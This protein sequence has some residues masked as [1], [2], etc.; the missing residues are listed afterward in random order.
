MSFSLRL[1]WA[2]LAAPFFLLLVGCEKPLEKNKVPV[3]DLQ[4]HRGA[5]GLLPENTVEGFIKALELGATTLEMDV[6]VTADSQAVLS[7][8]PWFSAEICS[9]PDGR[10]VSEKD[11][12][13]LFS[14][15]YDSIRQYDC[16]Q[17]GHPRFPKQQAQPAFKPLLRDVVNAVRD[18]CRGHDRDMPWFNIETKIK[19]EWEGRFTPSPDTFMRLVY[20]EICASGIRTYACVQSFDVRTLQVLQT[21]DPKMLCALLVE[22]DKPLEFNLSQ[23]GFVP[24]IY[25]PHHPLV[26]AALV[27]KAHG[28]QMRVIPWTVNDPSEIAKLKTLGVDGV[29]SDYPDLFQNFAENE[30]TKFRPAAETPE[31]T[32][33]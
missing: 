14:L 5:R 13:S 32:G 30:T 4:G 9:F 2:L 8:E 12:V 17:R 24:P 22:N 15:D 18:W 20:A 27:K 16:G 7:H 6:V 19:Q 33:R 28:L 31:R 29:I 11:T 26:D 3:F 10:P 1:V 21:L 23:L 25:S